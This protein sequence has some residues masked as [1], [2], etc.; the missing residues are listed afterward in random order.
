MKESTHSFGPARF[1][2]A[3]GIAAI[4]VVLFWHFLTQSAGATPVSLGAAG[5][6]SVVG[7]GGSVAIDSD[8]EIYQSA[9]VILG[10]VAEGPHTQLT[11]G[12]DA[13]VKGRWDYD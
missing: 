13:T 3:H 10:N 7:V 12:I 6:Y 1:S 8:F 11:H 4:L 2:L 9:T 5:D